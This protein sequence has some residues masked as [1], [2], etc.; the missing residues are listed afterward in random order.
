MNKRFS[1][2]I[3]ACAASL[4]MTASNLGAQVALTPEQQTAINSGEY[5]SGADLN[6]RVKEYFSNISKK[7]AEEAY[8]ENK[9]AQSK[10]TETDQKEVPEIKIFLKH[11]QFT[12]SQIISKEVL[13]EIAAKYQGR[14]IVIGDLYKACGEVN[15]IY[16][17]KGYLASK[18][19]IKAQKIDDGKIVITLVEGRV[20]QYGVKGN[21]ATKTRYIERYFDINSGEFP[22]FKEIQKDIQLF[23]N[24]NTTKLVVKMLPGKEPRTTDLYIVAVEP[25]K[26]EKLSI[27]SDNYGKENSGEWR[28]GL[29]FNNSNLTGYCDTLNLATV[30]AKTS[31]TTM[32]NY[33]FHTDNK[34]NKLSINHSTNSMRISK[35]IFKD[36]DVR[37]GSKVTGVT[38]SHPVVATSNRKQIL[39][40]GYTS[41]DSET[42][43]MGRRFVHD[44]SNK[45]SLSYD[46]L[47]VRKT[48]LFY[49]RPSY[50]HTE[51]SGMDENQATNK[52][53]LDMFWQKFKKNGDS[54]TLQFS[55]QKSFDDNLCSSDRFYIGGI[56]SVRGYDESLLWGDSGF[57]FKFDYFWHT[58][59]K[60]LR[61]ITFADYGRVSGNN[62]P[63]NKYLYSVGYGFEYRHK[64]LSMLATVGYALKDKIN[65]KDVDSS[66]VNLS[67][68]YMF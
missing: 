8:K 67:V 55:G 11:L 25:E 14:E 12:E 31:V 49:Y 26:K 24:T 7:Q 66:K 34:G 54:M 58:K 19:L 33:V 64:D 5:S 3:L 16:A 30:F 47:L 68:N 22:N 57:N 37:G 28:Y 46:N 43:I 63:M 44:Y 10:P 53:N 41:Q 2:I 60:G 20:S 1:N 13:D 9:E 65:N 17:K 61:L 32:L 42:K 18:A 39:N 29:N 35:G 50:S 56:Y 45:L 38:Y 40:L 23:N 21:K 4:L 27:F 48:D 15:A 62:V 36:L 6:Q 51:F 52:L 59:T